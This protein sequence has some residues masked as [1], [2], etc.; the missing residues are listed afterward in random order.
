MENNKY[1]KPGRGIPL[2]SLKHSLPEYNW[3]TIESNI[4]KE[5]I[6]KLRK[7]FKENIL[8]EIIN[9]PGGPDTLKDEVIFK[10]FDDVLIDVLLE[11]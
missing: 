11:E 7:K 2:D 5:F 10:C 4:P 6:R 9:G 8:D 3:T 1:L